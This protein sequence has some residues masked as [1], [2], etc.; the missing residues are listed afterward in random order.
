MAAQIT[1]TLALVAC[2]AALI[3]AANAIPRAA[4]SEKPY[5]VVDGN[6]IP[7]PLT[8]AKGDPV[9]G[10]KVAINR[11]QGNCL[12][13]HIMPIPDQQ[14]H[15]EVGPD[16]SEVASIYSE[17]EL[18]LRVVDP[19]VLN[20]DTIMPAFYRTEGLHRVMKNFQGKSV[21]TAQQVEDVVAYLMT[22]K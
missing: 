5:R 7:K 10:K 21:L 11:K 15:G 22:L 2:G 13:C 18:R 17:G 4:A 6:S 3:A 14:F 20:P 12:A 9:R 8:A 1:K 16:L 19:K